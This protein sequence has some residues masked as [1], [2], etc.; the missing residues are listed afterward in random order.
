MAVSTTATSGRTVALIL[1]AGA[2]ILVAAAA[3]AAAAPA[4]LV[5]VDAGTV[6]PS[7]RALADVPAR[8]LALDIAA[9]ATCPGLPWSAL[10]AI[11]TIE[12]DSGRS[13]AAGVRSGANAAGAEGPMQFE[14]ATFATY[15][16]PVPDGGARP[17]SPY[18]PTD[19]VYAAARLLCADG[20]GDPDRLRDAVFAYNHSDSYLDE[21]LTLAAEYS[22]SRPGTTIGSGVGG[23]ASAV[24]EAAVAFALDRLGVPYRWGGE[25]PSGFD[26][27]GLVQAAYAAAGISIPRVAQAQFEA[28]PHVPARAVLEPGDLVF[29]GSSPTDVT[30]V[31]MAVGISG[32]QPVMVDAPHTG[33]AVRVE[34]FPSVVGAPWG[35]DR[36]LGATRPATA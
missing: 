10:A 11:G 15:A 8:Y 24:A 27:S 3:A 19:A 5:G 18:D 29:F 32:G 20:G 34:P 25:G 1:T 16:L 28:G 14:P 17:P 9:A 7:S 35:G 4:I 33:A 26:C 30:H 23:D 13:T 31:G 12:S 21:V 6:T 36:Y 2:S 22:A